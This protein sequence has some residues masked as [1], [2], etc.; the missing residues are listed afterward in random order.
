MER[1]VGFLSGTGGRFGW[2]LQ[3]QSLARISPS[4]IRQ[5]LHSNDR[6]TFTLLD[7]LCAQFGL[8]TACESRNLAS[9]CSIRQSRKLN[10]TTI[11]DNSQLNV[12]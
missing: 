5:G 10:E 7:S 9:Y 4:S 6:F 8:I 12:H 11:N 2:N 1:M 3:R